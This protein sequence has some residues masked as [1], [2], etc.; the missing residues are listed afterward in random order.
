M[1]LHAEGPDGADTERVYDYAVACGGLEAKNRGIEVIE[2]QKV[3]VFEV[4]RKRSH[5]K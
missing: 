2:P 3:V 4:K 5:N 1:S